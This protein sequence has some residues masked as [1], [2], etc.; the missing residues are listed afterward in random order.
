MSKVKELLEERDYMEVA[1]IVKE[2]TGIEIIN[3][4]PDIYVPAIKKALNSL[5]DEVIKLNQNICKCKGKCE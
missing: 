5:K 3:T 4:T 1:D 2:I